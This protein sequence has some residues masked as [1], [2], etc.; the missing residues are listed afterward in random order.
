MAIYLDAK[1][2]ADSVSN[3]SGTEVSSSNFF[4]YLILRRIMVNH[5]EANGTIKLTGKNVK[6]D[7]DEAALIGQGNPQYFN[8]LDSK[9]PYNSPKWWSNGQKNVKYFLIMIKIRIRRSIV[10][11]L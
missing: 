11:I 10:P 5:L 8:P 7:I 6:D 3:L 4:A 1:I 2:I 9:N